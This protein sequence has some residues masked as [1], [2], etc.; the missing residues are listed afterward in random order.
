MKSVDIQL[1]RNATLKL[2]YNNKT[3]LVDPMFSPKE[4]F[5]SFVVL[6]QNLNPTVDLPNSI[7]EISKDVDL[8]L[9]SHL[10]PDHFD[11]AAIQALDF[12]LPTIV[13]PGD[14][15]AVKEAGF[16]NVTPLID[17]YGVDGIEFTRTNGQHGPDEVLEH[18]GE[19]SGFILKAEGYPTI[20]IVG[21]CIWTEEIKNTIKTFNPDIII[22]NSGG[23]EFMGQAQILMNATDTVE[24][25]KYAPNA[26]VVAVHMESLDHCKTTR[27][28]LKEEAEN[29]GVEVYIP[30][31]GETITIE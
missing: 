23:A 18:L 5:M 3:I 22:T 30:K 29:A 16:T 17:T 14:L 10:H 24:L 15:N 20:Y 1:I 12:S 8:L 6:D 27:S 7:E 19:V 4:S 2:K 11:P 31:D 13:Q 26:K 9:V 21:D 28:I 25:A